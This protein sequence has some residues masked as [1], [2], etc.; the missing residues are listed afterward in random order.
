M[1]LWPLYGIVTLSRVGYVAA[2]AA[3]KKL[4]QSK[5]DHFWLGGIFLPGQFVREMMQFEDFLLAWNFCLLS[6]ERLKESPHSQYG[7]GGPLLRAWVEGW[8]SKEIPM[9]FAA[10]RVLAAK[11]GGRPIL[12]RRRKRREFDATKGYPGEDVVV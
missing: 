2:P 12:G 3:P 1:A 5:R 4:V 6:V 10:V 11:F 8:S 9:M 7:V